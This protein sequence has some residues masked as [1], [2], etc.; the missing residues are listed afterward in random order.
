MRSSGIDANE[1][2]VEAWR[3]SLIVQ[4]WTRRSPVFQAMPFHVAVLLSSVTDG[5]FMLGYFARLAPTAS[6]FGISDL[7]RFDDKRAYEK[8]VSD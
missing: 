5:L 4:R 7:G 3:I 8:T 1:W 6:L 2:L